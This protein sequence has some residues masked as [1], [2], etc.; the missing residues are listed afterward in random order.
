MGSKKWSSRASWFGSVSWWS[1]AVE[2]QI[3]ICISIYSLACF[4]SK[5]TLDRDEKKQKAG[6]EQ[7]PYVPCITVLLQSRSSR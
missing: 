3:M 7:A 5:K 2:I 4:S 1:G 6:Q